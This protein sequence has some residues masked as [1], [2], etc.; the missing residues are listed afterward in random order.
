MKRCNKCGT[1]TPN[2]NERFCPQCGSEMV[3][4]TTAQ[5][6]A[7]KQDNDGVPTMVGDKNLIN[8]S[9]II[10]KQDKYE[11]SNITINNNIT[12]DHSHTTVVCAVSGKRVYMD[13]SIV[14][15]QCGQTVAPEYY[16]ESTKRCENCERN[17]EQQFR[18]FVK[19]SL[20][21]NTLN[22]DIKNRLDS[23]GAEL[24]LTPEMQTDILRSVQRASTVKESVLS[25]MQQMELDRA[26]K[27]FVQAE[28]GN[29]QSA[30]IKVF[31]QLHNTTQNYEVDFWYYLA[32][33]VSD[34][35]SYI[36]NCENEMLDNFWQRYWAFIAYCHTESPKSS[37][38]ID[39]LH[40]N[41]AEHTA[42]INL[43]ETMYLMTCGCDSH[44]ASLLKQAVESLSQINV[45]HLSKPLVFICEIISDV[46]Q[47]GI[48]NNLDYPEKERFA[49]IRILHADRFVQYAQ[50]QRAKQQAIEQ[51]R[52]EEEEMKKLREEEERKLREQQAREEEERAR[53]AEQKRIEAEQEAMM[54]KELNRLGVETD[55]APRDFVGYT[56]SLPKRKR[57]FGKILLLVLL[58]I[59]L[60]IGILFLIP[61]PENMQ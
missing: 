18:E 14:C 35:K 19:Q 27:R 47:T 56:T 26:I 32:N 31:E 60:L 50:M 41:F 11:A 29:E 57:S 8:D 6:T 53:I 5:T 1:T 25:K 17:A 7:T 58:F 48:K 13:N 33:A 16:I 24:L 34:P 30:A 45:E 44:D 54:K 4:S 15:P 10:G 51:K 39:A 20:Q 55:E 9:T 22:A 61:A 21:G 2:D 59:V 42:D 37:S 46:L 36:S 3:A 43:A 23:R 12:E 49:L 52:Q 40:K 38:A 28:D